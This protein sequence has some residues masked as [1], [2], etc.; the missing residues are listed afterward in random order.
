M[1]AQRLFPVQSV[2]ADH[3][4]PGFASPLKSGIKTSPLGPQGAWG[5]WGE[6][7]RVGDSRR[8]VLRKGV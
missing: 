5:G 7:Q 2:N 6:G 3:A 8:K 4:R 1:Q